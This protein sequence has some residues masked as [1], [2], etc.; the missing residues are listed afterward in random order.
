MTNIKIHFWSLTLNSLTL[1]LQI[2]LGEKDANI[3]L[4]L[5]KIQTF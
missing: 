5:T 1:L 4:A 3:Y 2:E